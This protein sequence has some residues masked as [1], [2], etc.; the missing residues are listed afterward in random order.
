[1]MMSLALAVAPATHAAYPDKPVKLIVGYAPGGSTD[2]VARLLA[3]A[4]SA[5][6]GQSV[7]VENK[8]GASGMIGA[9]QVVRSN[10]D[11][12]TLLL[13]YTPEVS[14]NKLVFKSMR[15]DPV[16][17]FSALALIASA[18]LVLASGPK[19][20]AKSMKELLAHK[21]KVDQLT[22]GSPGVGGQQH[23]AG[24]VLKNLSGLPLT[25]IP[26]RGTALAVGDLVG[27]QI[28]LFFATTP[29]L[30]ANIRAGKLNP[31]LVAGDKRERL[32][33]D[34][35]T[36]VELGM[37]KLQL[38]N[39][40]GLFGPK[41]LSADVSQKLSGDVMAVSGEPAFIKA[42]EDQGLSATPLQGKDFK[43]FINDEMKKY[44]A[45]VAETGIS[46]Q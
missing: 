43:A 41:G 37:P 28:D 3:N 29:P 45:I 19:L 35:P 30:L 36:A 2:I 34:V 1:M 38:T 17:D 33:P 23:M 4:L 42:L 26:Y 27:G 12:Y 10:P 8:S 15:Y 40:F 14:I 5:K 39:W 32:L 31:I 18:P 13:G 25:H 46:A 6:W 44:T 11:G 16:E 20:H 22:Y 7:V 24:E 9:E 21:G